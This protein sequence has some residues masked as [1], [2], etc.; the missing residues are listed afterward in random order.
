MKLTSRRHVR[1][2]PARL[3]A[4]TGL[5][6]LIAAFF[7]AAATSGQATHFSVSAPAT[8]TA[9]TEFI[10]TVTALDGSGNP[11]NSYRDT[12]TLSYTGPSNSPNGTAPSYPNPVVFAQG[13]A[14]VPV[15]LFRAETTTLTVAESGNPSIL[16]GTSG[17][18]TVGP[19]PADA[20]DFSQ[21]PPVWAQKATPFNAAV[22]V[23]D[24]WGNT[25]PNHNVS[26]V[27]GNNPGGATLTCPSTASPCVAAS[28]PS[29]VASFTLQLD[30]DSIG[31]TLDATGSPQASSQAF[32]VADVLNNGCPPACSQTGSD[33]DDHPD[34]PTTAFTSV[35]GVFTGDRLAV[36]V[37]E[38]LNIPSNVLSFCSGFRGQVGSA[39]VFEAVQ[40]SG[41]TDHPSWTVT[42]TV[43]K[44]ALD[45]VNRGAASYEICLG[46]INISTTTPTV[47]E[48]DPNPP[49]GTPYSTD[50]SWPKK[51]GGCATFDPGTGKFWGSVPNA[52]GNQKTCES[53]APVRAPVVTQKKKTAAG[54]LVITLCIPYPW[55]GWGGS[56]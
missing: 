44:D 41:D 34:D 12:H 55:D 48:C 37:D 1:R 13:V 20:L 17:S 40:T 49:G 11:D 36:T 7:A 16:P 2:K 15:T 56:G 54:D 31:Y 10:V 35:S 53:P 4:L 30:A 22:T 46:T 3:L 18:I 50:E 39:F 14:S 45:D 43:D 52:A 47:G 33:S 24:A 19:G 38:S 9:G 51:G 25:V 26:I 27:L 28:N 6:V 23:T 8:A 32:S 29:G 21:E 42:S 5:G